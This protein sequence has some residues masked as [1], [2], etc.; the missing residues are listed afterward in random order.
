[1]RAPRAACTR[2]RTIAP[3]Q[4]EEHMKRIEQRAGALQVCKK[5]EAIAATIV[6]S[7]WSAVFK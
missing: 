1:M 5:L 4:Y 3:V 6:L 7:I 2:A